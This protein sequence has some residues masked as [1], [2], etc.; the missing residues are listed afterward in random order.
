MTACVVR[1][2]GLVLALCASGCLPPEWGANAILH[3]Y[4]RRTTVVPPLPFEPLEFT[5]GGITIEGWRFRTSAPRRGLI[6]YLHGSADNRQSGLGFAQRFV[7]QGFD[8]VAYDS[9]AH[10]NSGGEACTYGFHE[11][12]DLGRALDVIEADSAI[13]FGTSLGGAVALQA[14]AEDPRVIGVIAQSPFSDL[15]TIVR[16]RA[17]FIA[18]DADIKA[19]LAIAETK[20]R[21]RVAEV[22]PQ[23]AA[24]RIRVPVLLIH[25]EKD[26]ETGAS[27]SQR[28]LA[29]LP[30]D[31][32]LLIVPGA[33]HNDTLAHAGAWKRIDAWLAAVAPLRGG[34]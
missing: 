21:F 19:A 34:R 24:A 7:P 13:L 8:V 25:G 4:R 28:I 5:S 12:A 6:V 10:G 1:I 30:G 11:K 27:H 14:A 9:R 2:A 18:S 31:K 20:G 16:E 3:P 33:G 15:E 29:A 23:A 22:S 32:D 17:P 26:R